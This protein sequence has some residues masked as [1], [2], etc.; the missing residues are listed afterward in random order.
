MNT[1]LTLIP[2]SE[3]E[4]LEWLTPA[5]DKEA[6]AM[7]THEFKSAWA[8]VFYLYGGLH[9]DGALEHGTQIIAT[10]EEAD[11]TKDIDPRLLAPYYVES[12]W[13]LVLAP[14]AQEAWRRYEL[15]LLHDDEMY[16]SDAQRAGFLERRRVE[17]S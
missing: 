7:D 17:N 9:P 3:Q 15:H 16:C 14:L 6:Q 12:G 5:L 2:S 13:P 4:A 1:P 8:A 11:A 10:R